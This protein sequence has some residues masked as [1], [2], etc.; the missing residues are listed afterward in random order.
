ME[1]SASGNFSKLAHAV[2]LARRRV[3]PAAA[4][5]FE[6]TPF[7]PNTNLDLDLDF[8]LDLGEQESQ[9]ER[10]VARTLTF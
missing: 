3:G 9:T 7:P 10:G 8:D 4:A 5:N 1:V 2:D 6:P